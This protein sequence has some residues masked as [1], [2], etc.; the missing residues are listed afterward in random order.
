M[1]VNVQEAL[2]TKAFA[3][4]KLLAGKQGVNRE[5][6]VFEI[7]EEPNVDWLTEGVLLLTNF[8]SLRNQPEKQIEVFQKLIDVNAAGLVIRLGPYINELPEEIYHLAEKHQIPVI[9]VPH[10]TAF[11][12]IS[13]MLVRYINNSQAPMEAKKLFEVVFELSKQIDSKIVV[14]NANH[15]VMTFSNFPEENDFKFFQKVDFPKMIDIYRT[16]YFICKD[17]GQQYGNLVIPLIHNLRLKG[18]LHI[19]CNEPSMI[20]KRYKKNI[21]KAIGFVLNVLDTFEMRLVWNGFLRKKELYSIVEAS[22]KMALKSNFII[23]S[24]KDTFTPYYNIQKMNIIIEHVGLLLARRYFPIYK[25]KEAD[26]VFILI[27]KDEQIDLETIKAD[28]NLLSDE[29]NRWFQHQLVFFLS[30]VYT[31]KHSFDKAWDEIQ[32]LADVQKMF[33]LNG[34]IIDYQSI[35]MHHYLYRLKND[36]NSLQFSESVIRTLIE[37]DKQNNQSLI[38]TLQVFLENYGNQ[39]KTAEELYIHRRTLSYRLKRINEITNLDLQIF[40]HRLILWL[41]IKLI[42]SN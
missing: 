16:D 9:S 30:Q 2:N 31:D 8:Y 10:E 3:E 27:A 41:A 26:Q 24:I 39:K 18:Y 33:Q 11:L 32:Y 29:I 38:E 37:Y 7:L 42:H 28:L 35:G 36:R 15:E 19:Y 17:A 20:I 13:N 34:R 23:F 40:E 25:V 5:I 14:T 4:V 6:K 12:T 21:D 22:G 1:H